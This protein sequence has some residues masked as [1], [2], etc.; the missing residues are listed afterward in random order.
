MHLVRQT[1]LIETVN[2]LLQYK[3]EVKSVRKRV[4]EGKIAM[5]E[6]LH[7]ILMALVLPMQI[8][9]RLMDQEMQVMILESL[10]NHY[11]N[12]ILIL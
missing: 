2:D 9:I 5:R 11:I 4:K 7:R 6:E 3:L 1:S 8:E 12:V 10:V